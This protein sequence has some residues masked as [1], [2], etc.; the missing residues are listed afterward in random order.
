MNNETLKDVK[1]KHCIKKKDYNNV[2]EKARILGDTNI[3]KTGVKMHLY[4]FDLFI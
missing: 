4:H 2:T 1:S 3:D